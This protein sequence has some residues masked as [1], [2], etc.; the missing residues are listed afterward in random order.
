MSSAVWW[1]SETRDRLRRSGRPRH[2]PSHP[3]ETAVSK[4]NHLPP[5][6]SL[7]VCLPLGK[8]GPSSV[9]PKGIETIAESGG[10]LAGGAEPGGPAPGLSPSSCLCHPPTQAAVSRTTAR[11]CCAS[12]SRDICWWGEPLPVYHAQKQ[13][14][15]EVR[16]LRSNNHN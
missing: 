7:D 16:V 12:S 5:K 15:A 10:S 13:K 4:A 14:P 1:T 2:H 8:A 11:R 9:P 3:L 6:S